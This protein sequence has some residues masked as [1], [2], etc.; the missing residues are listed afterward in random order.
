MVGALRGI[1]A[2]LD[3]NHAVLPL[4]V[5][6]HCGGAGKLLDGLLRPLPQLDYSHVQNK[7]GVVAEL[8]EAL[9]WGDCLRIL[10]QG[11]AEAL[12]RT[13]ESIGQ[14]VADWMGRAMQPQ[15]PL[16]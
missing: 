9:D 2:A 8:I 7:G 15:L 13:N 5:V 12:A 4:Q 3:S 11:H 14:Q 10:R 6:E 16:G 1:S